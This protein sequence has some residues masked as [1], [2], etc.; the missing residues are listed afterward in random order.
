MTENNTLAC[1][2]DCAPNADSSDNSAFAEL[3]AFIEEKKDEPGNLIVIL[4]KA[5]SLFGYLSKETVAHISAMTGNTQAK[6]YGVA[7]FYAQFRL[8]PIGKNL[9][10]LCQG[11]A[12]HVNGSGEI[13]KA[14]E[15]ELK[16]KDG[17]T[18]ADGFFTLNNV[19]CLGCCSLAPVMMIQNDEG[20]ETFGYLTKEKVVEILRKIK[21]DA[22]QDDATEK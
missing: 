13:E 19:A 6:I 21:E 2:C 16:I 20:E 15:E 8:A 10:M 1:K 14:I 4:Q 17:E 3:D 7:T 22:A 9:I 5:Q 18:D 11:T 12:C